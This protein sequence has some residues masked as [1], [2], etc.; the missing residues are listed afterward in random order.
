TRDIMVNS[1]GQS[2]PLMKDA[3]QTII[4]RK[5][6]IKMQPEDSTNKHV[7]SPVKLANRTVPDVSVVSEL[8]MQNQESLK[9][10]QLTIQS[11]N[12]AEL[13]D[14]IIADLQELK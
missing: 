4:G 10:L 5:N 11:K 13:F 3:L 6:F 14:F 7:P 2:D 9:K 1:L 8:I 12:G